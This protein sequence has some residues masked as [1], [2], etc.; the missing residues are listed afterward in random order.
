MKKLFVLLLLLVMC[1]C[2]PRSAQVV[3]PSAVPERII[4]KT[5]IAP[6]PA[7][8]VR[9]DDP[10]QECA[11]VGTGG[12][13]VAAGTELHPEELLRRIRISYMIQDAELSELLIARR[14]MNGKLYT[15]RIG[16]E[17]RCFDQP[18]LTTEPNPAMKQVCEELK[19]GILA[20]AVLIQN[21]AYAWGCKDGEAVILAQIRE[22]D[23]A[24]YDRSAWVEIPAP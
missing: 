23:E 17:N 24:G 14:C 11:A 8:T 7:G 13:T 21:T 4:S 9:E 15:C 1:G 19:D 2:T 20:D 6:S 5:A 18:D 16:T 12:I 10:W 22:T 3:R